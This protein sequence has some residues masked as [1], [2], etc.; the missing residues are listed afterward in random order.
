M[1][2]MFWHGRAR[3]FRVLSQIFCN[4][5]LILN[6]KGLSKKN[7]SSRKKVPQDLVSMNQAKKSGSKSSKG[8]RNGNN[9]FFF[10]ECAYLIEDAHTS[11]VIESLV[12][13]YIFFCCTHTTQ[14]CS[15]V[16]HIHTVFINNYMY[17]SMSN[18]QNVIC[19]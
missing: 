18:I 15:Y 8:L 4:L 12:C 9:S 2:L 7:L 13:K 16:F 1:P 11:S 6:L 10:R 17:L 19:K 14:I 3:I 5:I